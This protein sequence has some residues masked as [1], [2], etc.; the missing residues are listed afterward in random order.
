MV[1]AVTIDVNVSVGMIPATFIQG[2][3]ISSVQQSVLY[4]PAGNDV[5]VLVQYPTISDGTGCQSEFYYKA[6]RQTPD[7]DMSTVSY[8]VPVDNDPDNLGQTISTFLI[9]AAD[10]G[11]SGAFWWRVDFL[12]ALGNRTS[13]G[14]G[15]L[16]VEAV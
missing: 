14:F 15:T 7:N 11:E 12:D 2:D 5:Q 9:S 8:A 13:V 1:R 16:I 4:F 10:N 6:D 3:E